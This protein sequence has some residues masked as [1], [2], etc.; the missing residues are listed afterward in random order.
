MNFN[1]LFKLIMED[2]AA[3]AGGVFGSGE[4][5]G[6]GGAIGND[7]FWNRDDAR[8]PFVMGYFTRQGKLKPKA[9]KRKSKLKKRKK[10]TKS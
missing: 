8:I 9:K 10:R 4:S 7:D 5:F 1:Q 3:G 6:H 2:N